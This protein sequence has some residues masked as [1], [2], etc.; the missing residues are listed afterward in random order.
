MRVNMAVSKRLSVIFLLLAYALFSVI[1]AM[2]EGKYDLEFR[3]ADVKD[4]LRLLSDQ[5]KINILISDDVSGNITASFRGVTFDE[6]LGSVLRM[7]DLKAVRDGSIL[8]VESRAALV[9]RGE[10]LTGRLYHLNFARAS[11]LAKTVEKT[12]TSDGSVTID[13]RTNSLLVRD[14]TDSLLQLAGL[15]EELDRPTPQVMIEARI[16]EATTSFARELGI[17]WGFNYKHTGS[18][19]QVEV[20]GTGTNNSLVNLPSDPV[21]GGVG[22]SLGRLSGTLDLDLELTAMEDKGWGKIISSPRIATLENNEARIKS[23]VRIPIQEVTVQEGIGTT[24]TNFV[25]AVLSLTVK[26]QVTSQGRIILEIVADRSVPD[27]S[28]SVGGFPTILTREAQTQVMVKD[29]ET[30]VIGGLLQETESESKSRVPLISDIP[31]IGAAF[32]NK[33]KTRDTEELLIFITPK[34]ITL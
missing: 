3:D 2:A 1:P 13:E 20:S 27:W 28:R 4:V 23:G 32:Q 30:V 31:I 8:R 11:L 34:L 6:I 26:P 7:N 14:T 16:V 24:E 19:N 5:E 12:L 18:V 9:S 33:N 25:E 17:R 10:T 21:H 29:G 15:I 22:L